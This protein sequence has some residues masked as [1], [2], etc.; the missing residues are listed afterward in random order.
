MLKFI[1]ICVAIVALSFLI[2]PMISG[3]SNERDAIAERQIKISQ[4]DTSAPS[5]DTLSF[6][7]IYASVDEQTI[8]P[9]ALNNIMPAAGDNSSNS[10]IPEDFSVQSKPEKHPAL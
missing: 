10:I 3:V 5:N 2:V 9:E 7:E 8:T 1:Y 4:T 6:E